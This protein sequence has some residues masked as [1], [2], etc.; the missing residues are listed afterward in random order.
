MKRRWS[1]RKNFFF[2]VLA[3][4]EYPAFL[5]VMLARIKEVLFFSSSA[6]AIVC[7]VMVMGAVSR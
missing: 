3:L 4:T 5:P 6:V 2:D 1:N 7:I